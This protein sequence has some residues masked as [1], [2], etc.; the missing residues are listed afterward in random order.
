MA[1]A[2]DRFRAG[3]PN[4]HIGADGKVVH[5][6]ALHQQMATLATRI[7]DNLQDPG[8]NCCIPSGY[9]YFLQFIAHDMVDSVVSFNVHDS[10]IIPGARNGRSEPLRLETLYGNG[11]DECPQAYEYTSHQQI[12]GLIPRTGCGWGGVQMSPCQRA[13][14]PAPFATLREIPRRKTER[15]WRRASYSQ[16]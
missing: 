14:P 2:S 7:A 6:T 16:K 5:R 13:I 12:R 9:T 1:P 11:P 4:G 10:D 8:D 15:A 3:G